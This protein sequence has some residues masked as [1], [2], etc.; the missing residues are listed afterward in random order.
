M[1]RIPFDLGRTAHVGLDQNA[2]AVAVAR[3]RRRVEHGLA[4]RRLGRPLPVGNDLLERRSGTRR[5]S[6]QGERRAHELHE[7]PPLPQDR[8][9]R[10]PG[11]FD[12]A[13]FEL[14]QTTPETGARRFALCGFR[15][16]ERQ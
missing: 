13:A 8:L 15:G 6:R 9:A 12:R 1:Q 7:L 10:G 2:R 11:V 14:V 5:R 4:V 16:I 3:D